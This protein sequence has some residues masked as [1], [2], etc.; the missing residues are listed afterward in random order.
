MEL[1]IWCPTCKGEKKQWRNDGSGSGNVLDDCFTCGGRGY[2]FP[3]QE[4]LDDLECAEI[5]EKLIHN[6]FDI[7]FTIS[8]TT[9]E[10][11][12]DIRKRHPSFNW[13]GKIYRGLSRVEVLRK[14]KEWIEVKGG[15]NDQTL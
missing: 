15:Q 9:K 8:E 7:R 5:E 1:K 12:L 14:S 3:L 2:T 10:Y 11:V 13:D 4:V 6:G